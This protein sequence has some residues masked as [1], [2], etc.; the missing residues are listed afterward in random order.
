MA[1]RVEN[2]TVKSQS[3]PVV[4]GLSF[5]VSPRQTLALVGESGCGKTVTA[6]SVMGLLPAGLKVAGGEIALGGERLTGLS[7]KELGKRRGKLMSMI[8]QEPMTA[9]NPVMTI[10]RQITETIEAHKARGKRESKAYALDLLREV[11]LEAAEKIFRSYP[12]E[13]SGGMRQRVMCVIA[14]CASPKLIIADEP[15]TALDAT[16]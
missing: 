3:F 4:D 7:P 15:T 13:L 1:L 5:H 16:I 12:H 10:G 6:L 14:I 8:F 11:G 2:L 9:L